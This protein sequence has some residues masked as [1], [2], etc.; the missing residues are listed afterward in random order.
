MDT[1]GY[2]LLPSSGEPSNPSATAVAPPAPA[3]PAEE[4]PLS[5]GGDATPL[6]NDARTP[7][8][9]DDGEDVVR[10]WH[11]DHA[12]LLRDFLQ[13]CSDEEWMVMATI[14]K[15][16]PVPPVCGLPTRAP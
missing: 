12:G 4:E 15:E 1:D 3:P 14:W 8:A 11:R 10:R 6:L 9:L 13:I 2:V 7:R 16:G 5:S